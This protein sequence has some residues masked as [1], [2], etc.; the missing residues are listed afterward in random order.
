MEMST[1]IRIGLAVRSRC[2]TASLA[3]DMRS[4][5]PIALMS[6]DKCQRISL[7]TPKEAANRNDELICWVYSPSGQG[8]MYIYPL[9][10]THPGIPILPASKLCNLKN[11]ETIVAPRHVVLAMGW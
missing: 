9:G 4:P 8:Y 3:R 1:A 6:L 5:A 10:R 2:V 7:I 11:T